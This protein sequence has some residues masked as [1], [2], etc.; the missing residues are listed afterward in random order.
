MKILS[1]R[2]AP[3]AP[4][5]VFVLTV[6]SLCLPTLSLAESLKITSNPLGA[7]VELD[8]VPVGTTPFEKDFPGGYFHR[9]HTV[10]GERLEHGMVARISLPGYATHEIALTEGPMDWID[11]HGRHHGQ[12]WLFKAD[13]FHVDLDTIAST[14]S[15]AVA[16]AT[17]VRPAAAQPELSLEELVRRAKPAVVCLRGFDGFGSG[18]F[19]TE[20]GVIA[21]NAHVARGDS[22]LVVLLSD[23]AQL[24]AKV[25]YI[26]AELDIALV[27]AA[28]PAPSFR[29][30]HLALA[31]TSLVR[32]G[33]SV[34]AIGNPGDGMLFSATK[35]IVSSVGEFPSAGVGTWIQTDAQVNPGNSGGPLLNSHGEVIGLNT[36]KIVRKEVTG[37]SF[38]LSAGDLLKVLRRFYPDLAAPAP[39]TTASRSAEA[40]SNPE[41][42]PVTPTPVSGP[43]SSSP[44][45]ASTAAGFGVLTIT[46]DPDDAEIYIDG[47]FHG[48]A[49][50]T[51][52]LIAGSHTVV[53]KSSGL[54]DYTRALEVPASSKLSLKASL[55]TNR[56]P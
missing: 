4:S 56:E 39:V 9:T 26:D 38:A 34:V 7:T 3:F 25:V 1:D 29:F 27:K 40:A 12:Y 32:Q 36:S 31:D 22:T 21:T 14:F 46:S 47:K 13:H 51:L 37:I 35:G 5:L 49:P 44:L 16:A 18:F 45:A 53:L 8:G 24:P 19:V 48:N 42:S 2:Y 33:E 50:A 55:E 41:E 28:P 20:T 15:G 10:L 23:G 54:A 52:K 30:R 11:L 6:C 17:P 43:T